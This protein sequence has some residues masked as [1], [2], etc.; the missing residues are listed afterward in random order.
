MFT[1]H[2]IHTHINGVSVS[3]SYI[4]LVPSTI[5]LVLNTSKL[6]VGKFEVRYYQQCETEKLGHKQILW[7]FE[8]LLTARVW[9]FTSAPINMLARKWWKKHA[10][11]YKMAHTHFTAKSIALI[12]DYGGK[13]MQIRFFYQIY[14]KKQKIE[15]IFAVTNI[16]PCKN[17]NKNSLKPFQRRKS[18][19]FFQKCHRWQKINKLYATE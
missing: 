10:K 7:I 17:P 15:Y 6:Y 11:P 13:S 12:M 5:V 16:F 18:R 4:A 8:S 1:N 14:S 9:L 19:Q 3:S 2:P